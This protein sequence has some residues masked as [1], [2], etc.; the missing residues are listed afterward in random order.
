MCTLCFWLVL[1]ECHSQNSVKRCHLGDAQ[2]HH[3][4]STVMGFSFKNLT[5]ILNFPLGN[6]FTYRA[7][8]YIGCI[9]LLLRALVHVLRHLQSQSETYFVCRGQ[10]ESF[11][12][13][14]EQSVWSTAVCF[15]ITPLSTY[16]LLT[17]M[18]KSSSE[19]NYK[20]CS[21]KLCE[22]TTLWGTEKQLQ[23]HFS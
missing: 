10:M 4:A 21:E 6:A 2:T 1:W 22:L 16:T 13:N 18:F 15:K 19:S 7:N 11:K 14:R 17:V 23:E 9:K 20:R 5:T 8:V 3:L 12:Q